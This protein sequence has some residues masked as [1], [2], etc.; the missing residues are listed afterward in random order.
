[1]RD[2]NLLLERWRN[3]LRDQNLPEIVTWLPYESMILR[4]HLY[5]RLPDSAVSDSTVMRALQ[6]LPKEKSGVFMLV[7]TDKGIVFSTLLMDSF[8]SDSGT[9]YGDQNFYF[10]VSPYVDHLE[11]VRS[12]V[13]WLGRRL[14]QRVSPKLSS[15]DFAFSASHVGAA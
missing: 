12:K 14:M 8:G 13:G 3:A 7:G 11:Q 9:F 10:W 15:L 4:D 2:G 1:M 6:L 5:Y